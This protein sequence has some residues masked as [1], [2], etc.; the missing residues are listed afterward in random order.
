MTTSLGG[1]P[2]Y[3]ELVLSIS[4]AGVGYNQRRL[5]GGAS[6]VQS[7]GASGGRTLTLSGE[8]WWDKAQVDQIYSLQS[9]GQPVELVHHRGTFTVLIVDTSQLQQSTD[10]RDPIDSDWYTGSITMIEV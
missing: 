2:L 3:D 7:D 5:I 9:L 8:D 1:I 4:G 10:Y 6:V